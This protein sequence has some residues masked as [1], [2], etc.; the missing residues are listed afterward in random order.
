M[1]YLNFNKGNAVATNKQ[2][3]LINIHKGRY[4]K[5]ARNEGGLR[6]WRMNSTD[7]LREMR[8]R[9]KGGPKSQKFCGCL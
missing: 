6:N 2:D 8:M 3:C 5:D 4:L 1:T 9:G 7:R